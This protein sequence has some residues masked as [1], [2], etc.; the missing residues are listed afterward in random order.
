MEEKLGGG[1]LIGMG[2]IEPYLAERLGIQTSR[3]G[4]AGPSSIWNRAEFGLESV[5]SDFLQP[6]TL[7]FH[8]LR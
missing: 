7:S 4:R 5:G 3:P 6:G 2:G 8:L 1:V